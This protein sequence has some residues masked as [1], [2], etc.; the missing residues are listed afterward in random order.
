VQTDNKY[1]IGKVRIRVEDIQYVHKLA[2]KHYG[3]HYLKYSLEI[4]FRCHLSNSNFSCVPISSEFLQ[5]Y[6]SNRISPFT[7]KKVSPLIS[8]HSVS[9]SFFHSICRDECPGIRFD[10]IGRN[11][12][13]YKGMRRQTVLWTVTPSVRTKCVSNVPKKKSIP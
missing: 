12:S 11:E 9:N 8:C 2:R 1:W 4:D 10:K 6:F 13:K 3:R 5:T 7:L